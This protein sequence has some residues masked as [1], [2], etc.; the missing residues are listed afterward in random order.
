MDANKKVDLDHVQCPPESK[1]LMNIIKNH[2]LRFSIAASSSIPWIYMAQFWHTL[3]KDGSKYRLTFMLDKKVLSP[4]LDDFRTIFHLPQANDNNHDSFVPPPSFLDMVLFYKQQLGFTMELKTSS[5]FKTTDTRQMMYA[6][7]NN[8]HRDDQLLLDEPL[9]EMEHNGAVRSPNPKMDTA[10]SSA[11]KRSTVIRFRLPKR[12]STRLTPP[13]LVP[14]VDKADEM[15]LQY[16]LQA[17]P[18]MKRKS[19]DVEISNDEEVENYVKGFLS[20]K[21]FDTLVDHLQEVMVESLPTMVDKHIKEQVKKK[22]PE[23]SVGIYRLKSQ[24]QK[25]IDNHIPSQVDASV[26][27]YMSGH[28]LYVHPVQSQAPSVPEQQYQLYLSMK[29]DPRLQQQVIAIWLALQMK[30]ENL[31]VPQTTCRPYAVRPRDQDDPHDDAHPEG[32]NLNEEERGPSTSGNQEQVDD[33]DFWTDSYASDDDEISTKQVLQDIMEEV[34]L[35]IDEAKLKKMVDE[36]LRQRCTSGDEHQY[37]IDQMKNFLKSDIVWESRK[38]IL[39][40]P[41]PQ[42]TTPLKNPHAKIFYIKKQKEPGKPKEEVYSNSNINQVIKTYWELGHEHKFITEIVARRAN[43]CVMSITEPDY[44][45][46]NKN[47]I[48]DMYL[49]IMNG[50]VLDYAETGLLWSLSVFIRSSVIW[51]TVHDFQLGIESYQQKVNLTAPTISFLGVEKHKMFSI[52]YEPVHGIIYKNSKKEKRVMRHLEIHKFCDATLNTELE[53]LK[54]YSNDVNKIEVSQPYE[55]MGDVCEWKTTWTTKG[56]PR[57]IDPQGRLLDKQDLTKTLAKKRAGEKK[58]KE[59][60]KKKKLEDVA[61]EQESPKSDK[62]V[63]A[64]YEHEKEE[65]RIWLTVVSDEEETVDLKI[66]NFDR[67]DLV[68]LH[69]LVMKRFEDTTLEG[70]NLLLWGDLKFNMLVEKRY[71]LIKEMLQKMLNWKLEVEAESTMAFE[72]LKFIK[73]EAVPRFKVNPKI[74]YVFLSTSLL[75]SVAYKDGQRLT[76]SSDGDANQTNDRFKKDNGYHVVPPP[77]TGNYMSPLA[78]LSFTGLDDS[79]YRPTTN[80]TSVSMSK[81]ET[82]ITPPSNTSV[83]MT[84]VE[85]VRPSGVIIKDWASDDDKDIFQSNDLQATDKPS[86]KRIE[87]TNARNEFVKPKQAK[88]PRITTQNPK[89]DRRDWNGKMTQK[90]GLGFGSTKKA[91]FVC[92]IHNHLIKDCDFHEKRMAKKLVLKNM[93]KNTGQREI[94]PVWN[95]V[96]RI[97]HQN[98]FVSSAVLTSYK[99][100]DENDT[101][102]DSADGWD[103]E[104]EATKQSDAVRKEFEAQ[105]NKELFQGKATKASSTN[106]FNTVNT[107]VN[108]ASASRTSNDAGPSFVPLGRSFPLNVNDFPDDPL[109]PDLRKMAVNLKI[110]AFL[111]VLMMM[112]I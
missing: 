43:E 48:E 78:D 4:T 80:K 34:S 50:K 82:S 32:E 10:E 47:D 26:R 70:Y 13:A 90:L 52:I 11:Q 88:K 92:G 40:S 79:V 85:S 68:D 38:E 75:G 111:A 30:L 55:K 63:A 101:A 39:V 83:E 33:Y 44:K 24:I 57:I 86:F 56:T 65:L 100:S 17:R 60:A 21:S 53:G 97:N 109:M 96:Q 74:E 103:Q 28:I 42:K 5:S 66:L 29:N 1:I 25:E 108:A 37:H 102:D 104:K 110:L 15:I 107:P 9:K 87:F 51:E 62:E 16:T 72:L 99:N 94:R 67:Q 76:R 31:Q 18:K 6:F 59:S 81:V 58:S 2:P 41:H 61:E 73:H 27:S 19:S 22:V 7:V 64:D 93:G 36:M 49:M 105:F 3:K 8:I 89:V 23:Q 91:C 20:R 54:S 14:T 69:R 106:S 84:R 46:L 71:P 98:K 35:T 12:R 45:N 112:M 95:N 77:L